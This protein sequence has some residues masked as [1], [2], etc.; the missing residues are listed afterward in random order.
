[1]FARKLD[2]VKKLDIG[3]SPD[4]GVSGAVVLQDDSSTFLM[5]S[6]DQAT[7]L[8]IFDFERRSQS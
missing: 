3:F 6:R 2:I 1:M 5:L 4:S 7:F 8:D